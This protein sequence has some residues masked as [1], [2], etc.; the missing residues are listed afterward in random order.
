MCGL[1]V[2]VVCVCCGVLVCVVVWW[3]GGDGVCVLWCV[4]VCNASV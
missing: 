1:V 2:V 3:R 4:V